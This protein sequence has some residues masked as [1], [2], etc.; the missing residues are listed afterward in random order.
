MNWELWSRFISLS[1]SISKLFVYRLLIIEFYFPLFITVWWRPFFCFMGKISF[2]PTRWSSKFPRILIF[3]DCAIIC[4]HARLYLLFT[5]SRVPSVKW[6][7]Y[8]FPANILI[9]FVKATFKIIHH[10]AEDSSFFRD[11]QRQRDYY[12]RMFFL[13]FDIIESFIIKLDI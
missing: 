2:F 6:K 5:L 12:K 11:G 4:Y 9:Y 13:S 1:W 8:N 3:K 10:K 7:F